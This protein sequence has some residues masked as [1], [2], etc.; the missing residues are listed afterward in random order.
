[1]KKLLLFA[2][3]AVTTAGCADFETRRYV[4]VHHGNIHDTVLTSK[5]RFYF[6]EKAVDMCEGGSFTQVEY[7][8]AIE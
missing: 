8:K 5:Y 1:M 7:I 2:L 6:D 4:V 3:L